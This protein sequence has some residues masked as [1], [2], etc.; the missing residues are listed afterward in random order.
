MPV[1]GDLPQHFADAMGA[2]LGPDFPTDLGVAVSGGGDSM[3]MLHLA[4]GWARIYGIKLWVVTVDHGLRA[5]SAAEAAMVA[6]EAR[7]LG[8]T[9]S[10][11]R[12]EGWDGQGNLQA[13]ARRARLDLIG[14]WRGVVGHV[15][16]AHTMDDQAETFLMRLARGSGVE[17]LSAM[18][19]LSR[20]AQGAFMPLRMPDGP[21][22]P[23]TVQGH[24]HVVRPLLGATR[25]E[26]RHFAKLLHIPFVDDPS[27]ADPRFDR[28]KFRAL[29]D[30]LDAVGLSRSRLA[31][32]AMRQARARVAL[33]A[34]AHDVALRVAH[35]LDG[36]VVFDRDALAEIEADTQLRLVAA[37][38]QM[39]SSSPYRPRETALEAAVERAMSG[40]AAT[41]QGAILVPQG[42]KLWVAREHEAVAECATPAGPAGLWD[43]RWRIYGPD[44]QGKVIRPLGPVGLRQIDR[45]AG[46]PVPVVLS[47]PAVWDGDH[48]FAFK[49]AGYGPN[50]V[51]EH[52]PPGGSFP[53]R[54]L[55]H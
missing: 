21:P 3:V 39:V 50:Y 16:M 41:L 19:G 51:A 32:T 31:G 25:A 28:V 37:A 43:G 23:A 30:P 45:P 2:L 7:G 4:A 6:D 15:L 11:L 48:L 5:E 18:A 33:A 17:G 54:L 34:R 55:S 20:V 10:N 35:E 49:P 44:L 22:W 36:A 40:G 46:L 14:R 27:N 9:H 52:H 53:K 12:W 26:L 1:A 38:V 42:R 24:W 8:L 47:A 13:A 29:L